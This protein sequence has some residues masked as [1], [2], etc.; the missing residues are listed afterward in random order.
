VPTYV[1]LYRYTEKGIANIQEAPQRIAAAK[2]RLKAAGA[3]LVGVYLTTGQYDLVAISRWPDEYAA[4]RFL[5]EQGKEGRLRTE[6][7]RA[8]EEGEIAKILA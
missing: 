1:T 7:M 2:G 5:L 3:E 4:M 8:Y 6:T